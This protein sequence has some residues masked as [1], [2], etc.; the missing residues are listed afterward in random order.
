MR[1][2]MKIIHRALTGN[3]R[4]GMANP[5]E[6]LG[7]RHV[8]WVFSGG[9]GIH[10]WVCDSRAR[11]LP[12]EG[13]RA[14]ANYLTIARLGGQRR[15]SPQTLHPSIA[16][17]ME[18]V[19]ETFASTVLSQQDLLNSDKKTAILECLP[20]DIQKELLGK[21]DDTAN[22][23]SSQARWEQ[24]ET[25]VAKRA[26][27]SKGRDNLG[28]LARDLKLHCCFPRLDV[29]VSTSMN[30]L[31]KAPFCIHPR[32]S[33]DCF[34]GAFLLFRENLCSHFSRPVRLF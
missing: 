6:D 31:L 33:N 26:K 8:M 15:V 4:K 20:G 25:A 13:R 17:V 16:E 14:V 11:A 18:M 21:W 10:A 5:S 22:Y 3:P 1:L 9:R 30:H 29:N 28:T 27:Q 34:Y 24:L 2:A 7:F 12:N 19:E 32:S 23:T